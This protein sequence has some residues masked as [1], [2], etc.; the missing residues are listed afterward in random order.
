LRYTL[1]CADA[2]LMCARFNVSWSGKAP[3]CI[4]RWEAR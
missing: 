1:G 2:A 3:P 4:K